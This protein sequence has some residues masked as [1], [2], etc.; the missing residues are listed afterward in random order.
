MLGALLFKRGRLL[1]NLRNAIEGVCR[2]PVPHAVQN[3]TYI[4]EITTNKMQLCRLIY[5]P[6]S[7]LHVSGNVSAHHNEHLTVFTASGSIHQCCYRQV[8]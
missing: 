5:Y 6:L 2:F 3:E 7:A 4:A 1:Q 8:S